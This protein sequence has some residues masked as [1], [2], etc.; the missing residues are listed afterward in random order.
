MPKN[1]LKTTFFVDLK[2]ALEFKP[3][4]DYRLKRYLIE[5]KHFVKIVRFILYI[6]DVL[7]SH[8]PINRSFKC[9]LK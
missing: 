9:Q 8:K 7:A 6:T 3:I 5:D 4:T 2:C 1:K